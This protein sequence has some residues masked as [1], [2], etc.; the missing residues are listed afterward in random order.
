MALY[1]LMGGKGELVN[2]NLYV[3]RRKNNF[4]PPKHNDSSYPCS[5]VM[6][7]SRPSGRG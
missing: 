7:N 4:I 2:K 5:C 3:I 6:G 1:K